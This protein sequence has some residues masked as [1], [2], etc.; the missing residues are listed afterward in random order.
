MPTILATPVQYISSDHSYSYMTR[1]TTYLVNA[2][3]A[4]HPI[5]IL[6]EQKDQEVLGIFDDDEHIAEPDLTPSSKSSVGRLSIGAKV[7]IGIGTAAILSLLLGLLFWLLRRTAPKPTKIYP[8]GPDG[9]G[10]SRAVAC[11]T[12]SSTLSTTR[13]VEAGDVH[14]HPRRE[15]DPP[16]AYRENSPLRVMADDGPNENSPAEEELKVLKAQQEAI[17]R[18]IKQLE[19]NTPEDST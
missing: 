18:R 7:G 3:I 12:S 5:V 2:T 17:Q 14:S 1:I 15:V 10:G 11:Q 16:P 4:H 19:R 8:Y 6:F 13:D 9:T